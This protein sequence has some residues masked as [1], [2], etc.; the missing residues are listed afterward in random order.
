MKNIRENRYT[1]EQGKK[2]NSH[3]RNTSLVEGLKV[4]TSGAV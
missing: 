1:M 4:N 3:P 2:I